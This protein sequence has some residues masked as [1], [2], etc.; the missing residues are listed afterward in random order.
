MRKGLQ[1]TMQDICGE[2]GMSF[3]AVYNLFPSKDDIIAR[4]VAQSKEW[5]RFDSPPQS[6]SDQT[7]SGLFEAH[8]RS[9]LEDPERM[10][11]SGIFF[12]FVS[13]ATR[14]E[15]LSELARDIMDGITDDLA[16]IVSE[17]QRR[18]AVDAR[19]DPRCTA[20]VLMSL[21]HGIMVQQI[22]DPET[23]NTLALGKIGEVCFRGYHVMSGYFNNPEATAATVDDAGWLHSGDL[24]SMDKDGYVRITGRLKE[25]II[26]GGENIYPAEIEAYLFTHP[27]IA[28]VAV[29]G[30]PDEKLGEEI[31]AWVQFH[32]GEK[33]TEEELRE[34]CRHG[35]AHF[36][37]PRLIKFV[38]EFPMT[39][40]GK[41][42]KFRMREIMDAELK[43]ILNS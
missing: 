39:V 30:V 1:A 28:Q 16:G 38:D 4:M 29:F 6:T 18:G 37:V 9:R 42:Q 17:Q 25:M 20:W 14:D 2:A 43:S 21:V 7:V 8:L 36:K 40:T 41:I 33:M 34:F 24:G 35:L 12:E 5:N 15:R 13:A 23:K 3:G 10:R 26:R 11:G 22:V 32:Q 27:K 31:A 19:L